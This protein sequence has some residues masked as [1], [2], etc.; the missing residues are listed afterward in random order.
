L[1]KQTS[2]ANVVQNVKI[3]ILSNSLTQNNLCTF[4]KV[5]N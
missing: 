2:G 5:T 3:E 1:Q 4:V